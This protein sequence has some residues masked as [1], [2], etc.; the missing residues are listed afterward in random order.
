MPVSTTISSMVFLLIAV[1]SWHLAGDY[2]EMGGFFPKVIAVLLGLFSALQLV[3]CVIQKKKEQPFEGVEAKRLF[4]M[5]A[6]IVAY[7][8]LIFLIG[9]LP[10]S[11]LFLTFFFWFLGHGSVKGMSLLKSATISILISTGFFIV[12]YYIFNVPLP[13]GMFFDW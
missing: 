12:F 10:T 7:L 2:T 3:V 5:I 6:G 9:F 4:P 13:M 1:A 11:V 8:A